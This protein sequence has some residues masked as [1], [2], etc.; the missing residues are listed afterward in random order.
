MI[1]VITISGADTSDTMSQLGGSN[2]TWG[3]TAAITI[4]RR[5][6]FLKMSKAVDRTHSYMELL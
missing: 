2:A 4:Q 1:T 3:M 5:L 6:N